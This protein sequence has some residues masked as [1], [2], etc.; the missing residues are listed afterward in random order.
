MP[1]QLICQSFLYFDNIFKNF[2]R[3]HP[4]SPVVS[5]TR[6]WYSSLCQR[7]S[8]SMLGRSVILL[9]RLTSP[10]SPL[11]HMGP[12]SCTTSPISNSCLL[13]IL[14]RVVI[15]LIPPKVTQVVLISVFELG[16]DYCLFLFLFNFSAKD[17][18]GIVL[19]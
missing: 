17:L 9:L 19:L 1:R 16:C 15:V 4:D 2:A 18:N 5:A 14:V 6:Q 13:V 10:T 8:S 3:T 12:T 7:Y 11:A